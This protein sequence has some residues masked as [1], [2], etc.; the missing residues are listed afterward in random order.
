MKDVDSLKQY[1]W[2]EDDMD[3]AVYKSDSNYVLVGD[4]KALLAKSLCMRCGGLGYVLLV[5]TDGSGFE[6]RMPCGCT[7]SMNTPSKG[8]R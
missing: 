1:W 2:T 6:Q 7:A 8:V 5:A 4:V 3:E